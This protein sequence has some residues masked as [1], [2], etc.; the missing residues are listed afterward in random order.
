[1]GTVPVDEI[2][3]LVQHIVERAQVC[4]TEAGYTAQRCQE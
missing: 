2:T 3:E 4:R 1:M